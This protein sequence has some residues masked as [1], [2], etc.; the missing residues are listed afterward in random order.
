[1]KDNNRNSERRK[2]LQAISGLSISSLGMQKVTATTP[3]DDRTINYEDLSKRAK[4]I[5][6]SS[7]DDEEESPYS[8]KEFPDVFLVNKK[9]IYK[10]AKYRLNLTPVGDARFVI[11]LADSRV[12]DSDKSEVVEYSD[13]SARGK[14]IADDVI[15]D[16]RAYVQDNQGKGLPENIAKADIIKKDTNE[17]PITSL[18]ED[19]MK[20]LIHPY[21]IEQ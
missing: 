4:K 20:Y 9:L 6:K 2:I 11:S 14:S 21:R 18:N 10:G 19:K 13:L 16:G 8:Y 5:F 3:Q 17:Y 15:N 1:M 12:R 7:L